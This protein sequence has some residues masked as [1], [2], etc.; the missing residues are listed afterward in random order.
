[1]QK[2][3]NKKLKKNGPRVKPEK[4]IPNPSRILALPG[5]RRKVIHPALMN[6]KKRILHVLI[7]H[8]Q[9]KQ[10]NPSK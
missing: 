10:N 9:Q 7:N 3:P 5:N 1:M 2:N 8:R 6:L 4:N